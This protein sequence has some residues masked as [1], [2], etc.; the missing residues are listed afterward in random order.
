MKES[1]KRVRGSTSVQLVL[2]ACFVV[3][4]VAGI[5]L[6]TGTSRRSTR[7]TQVSRDLASM[8]A[9]GVDFSQ[10]ANRN[11]ARQ[12]L[13]RSDGRA[14][15]IL[16]RIHSVGPADCGNAPLV[17]CSNNGYAVIT[18]RIVIGDPQLRSSS[19]GAPLSIDQAT[20]SVLSWATDA[21]ARVTDSSVTLKPGESA[22]AA[23]AFITGPDEQTGVYARTL[24]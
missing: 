19:L 11:I 10:P 24:L 13:D 23:E 15:L 20:G 2:S 1:F 6:S 16:T 5:Y 7:A 21:S 8:Y 12:L 9:Q 18:Q 4:L 22:F 14:L 17:Q 3:P